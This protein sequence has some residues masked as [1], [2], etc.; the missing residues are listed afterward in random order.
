MLWKLIFCNMKLSFLRSNPDIAKDITLELKGS[1]LL[2]FADK[3]V[4]DTTLET[5]RIIEEA[6]KLDELLTIKQVSD[7][8][9]VSKTT[10]F[11]WNNNGTLTN[12][13]IGNKVRYRRSDVESALTER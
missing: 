6:S 3:L 13:R 12:L 4:I 11:H 10:L 8:L 5:K 7:Y 1:D 9:G 2:A